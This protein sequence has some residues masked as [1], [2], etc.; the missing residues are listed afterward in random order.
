MFRK[1]TWLQ[2]RPRL[3]QRFAENPQIYKQFGMRAHNGLDFGCRIGTP[4]F[5][6]FDGV[7]RIR[8]DKQ[9]GYGLHIKL[10]SKSKKLESVMGHLRSVEGK[11]GDWVHQGQLI[12][13]TGNT[14]FSTGP[15]LH[16]GLRSLSP[17]ATKDVF[18]WGV[19]NYDNGY[20][21]YWNPEPYTL[22]WKGTL[23]YNTH[24]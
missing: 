4:I 17:A 6:P 1:W 3:T 5:S 10:R 11:D 9:K 7:I 23:Q 20:Y 12:G 21:G 24:K 16:W 13:F 22:T 15:H 2:V 19:E 14:G 8:D 18:K